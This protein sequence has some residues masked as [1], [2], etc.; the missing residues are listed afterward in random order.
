MMELPRPIARSLGATEGLQLRKLTLAG[1]LTAAALL[2]STVS[3]PFGPT[4]CFPFQHAVNAVAGV[5]LGPW[6]ALAMAF[7]TSFLRVC[8]G[9]GSLF[10]FPGAMPGALAVGLAYK[11]LGRDWAAFAEPLVTGTLGAW[12]AAAVM[13]P[14][15][16]NQVAFGSLSVAFLISSAPGAAIGFGILATLRRM[17]VSIHSGQSG[18]DQ[19]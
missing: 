1:I 7:I 4:R 18:Q 6:W 10:A 12:L 8:L 16:G 11:T 19:D 14:A 5:L 2:L 15:I 9:T 13:A 3:I 17:G